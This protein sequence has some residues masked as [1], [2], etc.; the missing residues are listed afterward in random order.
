MIDHTTENARAALRT[1]LPKLEA[2]NA[3]LR[4]LVSSLLTPETIV[5]L[6]ADAV[7]PAELGADPVTAAATA[8]E[9]SLLL[10]QLDT[11]LVGLRVNNENLSGA[12][13]V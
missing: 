9:A 5:A 10:R 3:A 8:R 1:E 4:E 6:G 2:N 7:A 13:R 12:S 11:A